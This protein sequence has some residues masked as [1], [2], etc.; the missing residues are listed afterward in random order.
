M[1]VKRQPP[2]KKSEPVPQ[3]LQNYDFGA[4]LQALQNVDAMT[5]GAAAAGLNRNEGGKVSKGL[6]TS[7]RCAA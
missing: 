2:A 7:D 5:P 4:Q 1:T 3:I 6:S